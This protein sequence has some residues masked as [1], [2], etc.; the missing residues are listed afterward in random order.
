MVKMATC[1]VNILKSALGIQQTGP[2]TVIVPADPIIWDVSTSYEY[3]TLVA[4]TDFGQ[5][6]VSKKDVPAGTPLT[7][8]DYWVPVASF[9]AQLAQIQQQ[10]ATFTAEIAGKLSAIDT[11]NDFSTFSGSGVVVT[12]GYSTVG[13]GGGATYVI[14][15]SGAPDN[16]TTFATANGMATLVSLNTEMNAEQLGIFPDG[17]D[18]S[19]RFTTAINTAKSIGINKIVFGIGKYKF[20]AGIT[21]PS[22]TIVEGSFAL[23]NADISIAD[24]NFMTVFDFSNVPANTTCVTL[25][26][27]SALKNVHVSGNSYSV[28]V[29]RENVSNTVPYAFWSETV[30]AAN[31]TGINAIGFGVLIDKVHVSGMSN[32]G[33]VGPPMTFSSS[34]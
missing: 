3:L 1:D 30:G 4:S 13:D 32:A 12:R 2:R 31:V 7:D 25:S 14:G 6:Y 16:V 27:W 17:S 22:R 33:I 10:I 8:T 19:T 18:C 23:Y 11:T 24:E 20:N 9:N 29:T 21:V 5:G 26:A 34:I 15:Q 28:T